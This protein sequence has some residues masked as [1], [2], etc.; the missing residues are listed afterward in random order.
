[1]PVIKSFPT[2][3]VE[4]RPGPR[5]HAP[6]HFHIVSTESDASFNIE[7]LEPMKGKLPRHARDALDW[8]KEN[9]A[10][11]MEMWNELHKP[12]LKP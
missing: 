10:H 3:K 4:V 5:E 8:A 11:L 1:M 9:K 12:R 6:P 2:C 7:S